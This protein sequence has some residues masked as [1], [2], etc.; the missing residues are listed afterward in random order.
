MDNLWKGHA[1]RRT[2]DWK[3]FVTVEHER[4]ETHHENRGLSVLQICL[5][6]LLSCFIRNPSSGSLKSSSMCSIPES[7]PFQRELLDRGEFNIRP[8]AKF[9]QPFASCV[10]ENRRNNPVYTQGLPG[11]LLGFWRGQQL[12]SF[13]FVSTRK[14]KIVSYVYSSLLLH[15]HIATVLGWERRTR[16]QLD[17]SNFLHTPTLKYSPNLELGF[18]YQLSPT[19]TF[20]GCNKTLLHP[21][22]TL[23]GTKSAF[24]T[25]ILLFQKPE[26]QIVFPYP[27]L[28]Y[29]TIKVNESTG[30]ALE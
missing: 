16:C 20:F 12:F 13:R 6:Y 23:K 3:N 28:W 10:H 8:P 22:N 7:P 21:N 29:D 4:R 14:T 1:K 19:I 27:E 25:Q 26:K 15:K 18:Y 24:E 2:A 30:N 9:W 5:W 17:F 11:C